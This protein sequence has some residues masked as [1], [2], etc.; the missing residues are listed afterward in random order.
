MKTL[1][2]ARFLKR[3]YKAVTFILLVFIVAGQIGNISR[4]EKELQTA[5]NSNPEPEVITKEVEK[6][7]EIE[8]PIEVEKTPQACKDLVALDDE[9]IGKVGDYFNEMS[10]SAN[11]GDIMTFLEDNI[12]SVQ[13]LN[14]YTDSITDKRASLKDSC[15]K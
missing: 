1:R 12:N 4:L 9:I 3:N 15:L 7:V 5:Q 10:V 11:T 2:F 8:K 13:K 6:I 14:Q